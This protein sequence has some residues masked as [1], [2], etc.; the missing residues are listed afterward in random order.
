[1]VLDIEELT[2]DALLSIYD[3][4]K[5][6]GAPEGE[7]SEFIQYNNNQNISCC[8]VKDQNKVIA[9]FELRDTLKS[10]KNMSIL[11]TPDI[12]S[13][14]GDYNSVSERLLYI[15]NIIAKIFTHFIAEPIEKRGVIK[16]WNDRSDI[17][18]IIVSIATY[19][20]KNYGNQY[21]VKIYR[22]W[23]EVTKVEV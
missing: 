9:L 1:M 8:S 20:E 5:A 23:V 10:Y 11:L 18:T 19:L 4:W 6:A 2:H 7:L 12:G 13:T 3:K 14:E 15:T 21:S 17:H 16:I 22:N